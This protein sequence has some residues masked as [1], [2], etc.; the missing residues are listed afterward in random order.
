MAVFPHQVY[1]ESLMH[2]LI[3]SSTDAFQYVTVIIFSV[4]DACS[5]GVVIFIFSP[6]LFL[7]ST[8]FHTFTNSCIVFYSSFFF[9][10]YFSS[11]LIPF[12]LFLSILLS[13]PLVSDYITSSFISS[14]LPFLFLCFLSS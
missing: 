7:S 2:R 11:R 8:T 3:Q 6:L 12:C 10:C 5:H 13:S 9:S 1:L 4:C 14:Y